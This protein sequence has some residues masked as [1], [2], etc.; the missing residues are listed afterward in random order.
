[1]NTTTTQ[2]TAGTV[3]RRPTTPCRVFTP[4][5]ELTALVDA[6]VEAVDVRRWEE[7]ERLR[8]ALE[9][10]G[11]VTLFD[12]ELRLNGTTNFDDECICREVF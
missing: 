12:A 6:L 11:A 1:M 5:R 9:P 2:R 8:A 4:D 3:T 7:I 10:F